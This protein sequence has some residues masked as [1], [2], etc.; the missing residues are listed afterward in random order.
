[1]MCMNLYLNG[2]LY[3]F[4]FMV[5]TTIHENGYGI[6]TE[7]ALWLDPNEYFRVL[8]EFKDFYIS[9]DDFE[10]IELMSDELQDEFMA[11]LEEEVM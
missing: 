2:E 11:T 8:D 9:P 1:M 3:P 7:H 6:M 10:G 4:Y 5:A